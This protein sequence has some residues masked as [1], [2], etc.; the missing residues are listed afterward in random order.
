MLCPQ[1]FQRP[2]AGPVCRSFTLCS[3]RPEKE[4]G[5]GFLGCLFGLL[6][7]HLPFLLNN[8]ERT[9]KIKN[10]KS[11]GWK[12]FVSYK[13]IILQPALWSK[14][15]FLWSRDGLDPISSWPVSEN[16]ACGF[17]ASQHTECYFL[18]KW[19]VMSSVC[20]SGRGGL[21][22]CRRMCTCTSGLCGAE[23]TWEWFSTCCTYQRSF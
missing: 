23:R 12:H 9:K 19:L 2:G 18:N 16:R 11:Q 1:R 8:S 14:V 6:L 22:G 10:K 13:K 20:T 17:P 5:F 7:K 4:P 15:F 3:T 21:F